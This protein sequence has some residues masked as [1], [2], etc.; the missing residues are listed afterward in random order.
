MQAGKKP[1]AIIK[2]DRNSDSGVGIRQLRPE[3]IKS[4]LPVH[5][6]HLWES[7]DQLAWK[8]DIELFAVHDLTASDTTERLHQL[9]PSLGLVACFPSRLPKQFYSIPHFGFL[10]LHPSMLPAFRGP[11]PLFWTFRDGLQE[12]GVTLHVVDE[13]LDTGDIVLQAK[14][15]I[16][17][18][19]SGGDADMLFATEGIGLILEALSN[20]AHGDLPRR[21]QKQTGS[22]FGRP[23]WADFVIP[24]DWTARRAYNF[25]RGTADWRRPY[26]IVADSFE[27]LARIAIS[28]SNEEGLEAPIVQQGDEAWIKF[29]SGCLRVSTW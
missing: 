22:S 25:M 20:L 16:P 13:G 21:E 18:G 6:P 27:L 17:D 15:A 9:K 1:I 24:V 5:N 3:P 29:G 11:Y 26:R 2:S 23:S 12:S 10:N 28:F 7:I 4:I 19:I 14:V 8:H